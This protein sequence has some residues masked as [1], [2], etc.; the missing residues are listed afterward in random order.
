MESFVDDS[1][2]G[3]F[4]LLLA[5]IEEGFFLLLLSIKIVDGA[6]VRC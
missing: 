1:S 5:K 6:C 2:A 3:R 4:V